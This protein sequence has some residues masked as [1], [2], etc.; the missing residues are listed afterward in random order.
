MSN[1]LDSE[2]NYFNELILYGNVCYLED[3]DEQTCS[4][5]NKSTIRV[6]SD[7]LF[8]FASDMLERTIQL[9]PDNTA[10]VTFNVIREFGSYNSL[11]LIYSLVSDHSSPD[12]YFNNVTGLV[13][14]DRASYTGTFFIGLNQ[15][16]LTEQRNFYVFLTNT[17]SKQN[18][19][20]IYQTDKI[21][22]YNYVSRLTILPMN[23]SE[24]ENVFGFLQ[25]NLVVPCVLDKKN[26]SVSILV[27]RLG[28]N[29]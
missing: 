5:G 7:G 27:F 29:V 25:N 4:K 28:A 1:D 10:N 14:F 22:K 17:M 16:F 11:Y 20:V 15:F 21:S 6:E 24:F 8:R 23:Y 18:D 12:F 19:T 13:K 26:L 3:I 2:N 9:D